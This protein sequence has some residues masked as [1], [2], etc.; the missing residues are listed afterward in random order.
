MATAVQPA[1]IADRVR[2]LS[3]FMS[4]KKK[5]SKKF[6]LMLGAG[7]SLSSGVKLTKTIMEELTTKYPQEPAEA[8]VEDSFD[9]LWR[10]ASPD[11][12]DLMLSPY[13]KCSPSAGYGRL[14]ELIELG[15][16]DIII[17]FNFDNL[18]EDALNAIGFNDYKTIIRG[19]TDQDALPRLIQNKEPRVKI[20][21]MHGSLRSSDYFLFSKEEMANYPRDLV[22]IFDDLTRSDIIIC[23]Y[24]FSDNCVIRAFNV[25]KDSGSIYYVNPSG[26]PES[27]KSFLVARRSKDRVIQGDLGKFDQFFETLHRHLTVSATPAA[28]AAPVARQNPFKFLDHYHEENKEWFF[29]RK[30]LTRAL[31]KKF[32][33]AFPKNLVIT[34][35]P[36]VGKTSFVRAGLIPYLSPDR[37]ECIFVRSKADFD[38]QVRADFVQ[39]FPSLANLEWTEALSRLKE[40]TAK[41]VVVILDQFERPARFYEQRPERHQAAID[42]V[43][44]LCSRQNDQLAVVFISVEEE[45]LFWKLMAKL[46]LQVDAIKIDPIPVA[47]VATMMRKAALRG[48]FALDQKTIETLCARYNECLNLGS[49]DKRGFTLMHLQTFCY[50]AARGYSGNLDDYESANP[51][52]SVALGSLSED[53]GLIN[54]LDE[55]PA[56]ERKLIRGFLK[57]ICDPRSNTRRIVE[58][59]KDRFPEFREDRFPEPIV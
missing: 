33:T 20:L 41:R 15:F 52:L 48:G 27:V 24:A 44:D 11:Q 50:Y 37:Y 21:K 43:K 23:G 19:E 51:G 22:T 2:G 10:E 12:R 5:R 56:D 16:F 35:K 31:V 36:K 46:S 30:K 3:Q 9:K 53:S 7:A 32:N 17:T 47:R 40:A 1:P 49:G 29:G 25:D 34:G 13:L 45:Y 57:V 4:D 26:A 39:R 58:F 55:M 28:A 8:S 59:I 54:V 14:A 18:L 42:F 38:Q 6:V